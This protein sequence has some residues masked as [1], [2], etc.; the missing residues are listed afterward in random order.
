MII[1]PNGTGKSTMVAAIILGL[2]GTPK[3]VGRGSKISEYVKHDCEEAEIDILLQGDTDNKFI[4][5]TRR[6]NTHEKSVW[7]INNKVVKLGDLLDSIKKFNIQVNNLCQFLPQD[8]VQ[9]FAKLNKQQLLKETQIALCRQDL[10]ENQETLI[11]CR[12]QHKKMLASI[13]KNEKEL[14]ES[15]EANSRLEGL[16]KNFNQKKIYL[17]KIQHIE[18][19]IAWIMYDNI[20][21]K[22]QEAKNDK[23]KAS[24]LFETSKAG[25]EPIEKQITGHRESMQDY[26]QKALKI[27]CY[28]IICK[29]IQ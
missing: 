26:K 27:V 9:D 14:K 2:G 7:L 20:R 18:R 6:F 23:V 13:E 28:I 4:Q 29:H 24:Q 21:V 12:E 11:E 3:I 17:E 15:K 5:V 16:V 22:L 1:G 8:R 19:K 10:L 25:I